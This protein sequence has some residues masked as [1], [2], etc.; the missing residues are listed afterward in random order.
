MRLKETAGGITHNLSQTFL[1]AHDVVTT[2]I[3]FPMAGGQG[4]TMGKDGATWGSLT[5]PTPIYSLDLGGK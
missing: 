1:Q 5:A 3:V 2:L 4:P